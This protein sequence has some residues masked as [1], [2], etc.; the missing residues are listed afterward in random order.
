MK[1]NLAVC[2]KFHHANYVRFLSEAGVLNRFYYSHKWS[3]NA[4]LLGIKPAEA[5]N[6][7][8]KEYL[9]HSHIRIFN[10]RMA[11]FFYPLYQKIWETQVRYQWSQ[12]EIAHIM[13]Q[14]T[15]VTLAKDINKSGIPLIL[16]PVNAHPVLVTRLL[17]EEYERLGLGNRIELNKGQTQQIKEIA[18]ADYLLVPSDFVGKSFIDQGFPADKV[19]TIPL[20]VDLSRFSESKP[21]FSMKR[22]FRVICVS[23][24]SLRKAQIDL[25]TAWK[26]LNLPDSE[27]IFAGSMAD[28]M[29]FLEKEFTGNIR[30]LG[31]VPWKEIP[32]LLQNC[33][34]F[35]LPSIED[36]FGLAPI[37]AMASGL[38]AIVTENTGCSEQI[39]N[40]E[41]GFVVPI[42]N[43]AEIAARIEKLYIDRTL[44]KS[45]GEEAAGKSR[46]SMGWD[47]YADRLTDY[48]RSISETPPS[49]KKK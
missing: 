17:N 29:K 44:L 26:M 9:L 33:D 11:N 38:P 10:Q 6:L 25:I 22:A 32:A 19:K 27:L 15:A 5:V 14:G 46:E 48:Y 20:A 3:T 41:T 13:S 21:D 30:Y 28:E 8:M 49:Q 45:M 18:F 31:A 1:I 16:E 36:G 4:E 43:P 7:W 35:V 47:T 42:R 2:G 37:E 39:V 24:I 12:P 23:Q 34:V 40:G